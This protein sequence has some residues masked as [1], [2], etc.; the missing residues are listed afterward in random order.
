MRRVRRPSAIPIAGVCLLLGC[1]G[2][3]TGNQGEEGA[4]IGAAGSTGLTAGSSGS[5]VPGGQGGALLGGGGS[6]S[7]SGGSAQPGPSTQAPTIPNLPANGGSAGATGGTG[8]TET[9]PTQDPNPVD[10]DPVD[11]PPPPD[12]VCKRGIAIGRS[13]LTAAALRPGISWWYNWLTGMQQS[14]AGLEFAPM[15]WGDGFSVN[16]VVANIPQGAKVLLGFNEP[17][18][19]E[20]ADLSASQAAAL[21]PQLE[22][23][24]QQRGLELVSPG[25]NFCGDDANKTGPCHDTNPVDYLTEFFA[26]CQGCKVDHIAVHWYNCDGASLSWYLDQFRHF[27]KPIWLTEFACAYDG[28]TSVQGQEAYM[29]EAIPMLESDPQIGRYAWFSG[30][31]LPNARLING[32]G[33]LTP[34]GEVYAGL[35]QPN[36]L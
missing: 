15:V 24:A 30:D 18:F 21:W 12:P 25:V 31:P 27:G 3:I 20:Q 35:P 2:A 19:F 10:P 22:Q 16:D 33:S 29:R 7:N 5:A 4:P 32:D 36:C 8:G 34:L 17:N 13:N 11:P 23:I 9:D 14:A 26:Q 6:T 1:S 28:D